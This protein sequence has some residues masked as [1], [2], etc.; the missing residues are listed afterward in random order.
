MYIAANPWI[1]A[2]K[3]LVQSKV[4]SQMFFLD[5]EHFGTI[6]DSIPNICMQIWVF[7]SKFLDKIFAIPNIYMQIADLALYF[8]ASRHLSTELST[9]PVDK[10]ITACMKMFDTHENVCWAH[11]NVR[12]THENVCYACKCSEQLLAFMRVRSTYPQPIS[13]PYIKYLKNIK[14]L[15]Y[16]RYRRA[17]PLEAAYGSR[18]DDN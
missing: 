4:F 8:V 1:L 11:E 7:S 10:W 18:K 16:T 13:Y 17:A 5:I 12:W 15:L 6:A 3:C 14:I 9:E 2:W